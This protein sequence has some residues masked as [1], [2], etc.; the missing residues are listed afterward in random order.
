M[1]PT[2]P[3]CRC[4]L[5]LSLFLYLIAFNFVKGREGDNDL[6]WPAHVPQPSLP[7][8]VSTL[9]P[10]G[11]VNVQRRQFLILLKMTN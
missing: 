1:N 3:H 4:S 10:G 8:Y 6:I 9:D 5:S 7:F 11:D 2:S